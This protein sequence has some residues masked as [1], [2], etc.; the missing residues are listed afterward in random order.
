VSSAIE[1]IENRACELSG[2]SPCFYSDSCGSDDRGSGSTDT[3]PST[4]DNE[5]VITATHDNYPIET[6]WTVIDDS[7]GVVISRQADNSF[8]TEGRIL[9]E[10]AYLTQGSYTFEMTDSY[11]DGICCQDGNGKFAVTLYSNIVATGG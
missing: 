8:S 1:W 5:V 9:V 3:Q 10:A 6:G 2:T 4:G 7:S 11:V